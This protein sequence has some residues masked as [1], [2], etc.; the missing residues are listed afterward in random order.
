MLPMPAALAAS[1]AARLGLPYITQA[2]ADA[3]PPPSLNK[4]RSAA[5]RAPDDS[6]PVLWFWQMTEKDWDRQGHSYDVQKKQHR[7]LLTQ[8]QQRDKRREKER[9]KLRDRSARVRP[10]K[11]EGGV[12]RSSPLRDHKPEEPL[13]PNEGRAWSQGPGCRRAAIPRV[14]LGVGWQVPPSLPCTHVGPSI[15]PHG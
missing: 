12:Y 7:R 2:N 11:N 1:H 4:F 5:S 13:S 15:R 9:D 3:Y 6:P 14:T 10:A 8:Y